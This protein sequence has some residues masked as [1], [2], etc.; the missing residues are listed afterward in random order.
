MHTNKLNAT[1]TFCREQNVASVDPRRIQN[2]IILGGTYAF[3]ALTH[4]ISITVTSIEYLL[5]LCFHGVPIQVIDGPCGRVQIPALGTGIGMVLQKLQNCL[6]VPR[7]RYAACLHNEGANSIQ[8]IA[9]QA[10]DRHV[11][12]GSID[13]RDIS[14]YKKK[15]GSGKAQR[16]E[17]K[18]SY[19]KN[20]VIDDL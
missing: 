18:E 5:H 15:D 7:H 3:G 9:C 8:C 16:Q 19:L 2:S 20:S 1:C 17:V 4:P 14:V 13:H 12:C 6:S 11:Q 10:V